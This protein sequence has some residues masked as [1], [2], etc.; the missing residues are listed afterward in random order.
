[1][2]SLYR[3]HP[4]SVRA[5]LGRERGRMHFSPG[6]IGG[7]ADHRS[8]SSRQQIGLFESDILNSVTRSASC[9]PFAPTTSTT[10]SSSSSASTP[11]PTPTLNASSP[12]LAER[13]QLHERLLYAWGQRQLLVSDL[14]PRYGLHGGS[15]C[16]ETTTWALA[17]V[18][19]RPDEAG[20]PPPQ[21][22][23]ATGQPRAPNGLRTRITTSSEAS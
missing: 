6:P 18:A 5:R 22:L 3:N 15:F 10:S 20:G 2:S 16:L 21:V 7:H 13:H 9:L 17:T 1:M 19:T 4:Y 11:S 23:R 8:C 12:S 14:I